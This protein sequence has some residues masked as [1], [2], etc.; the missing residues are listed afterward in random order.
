[1]INDVVI[2]GA[3]RSIIGSNSGSL[4]SLSAGDLASS[5]IDYMLKEIEDKNG[6]FSRTEISSFISG[7]CVGSNIG[8]NLPRQIMEKC[9]IRETETAFSLNEMCGSGMEAVIQA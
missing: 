6:D 9:G 7:I 2:I 3:K 5:V 8:Q 1:M 4:K